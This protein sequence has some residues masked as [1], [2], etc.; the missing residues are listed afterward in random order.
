MQPREVTRATRAH[1]AVAGGSS[2]A[3]DGVH[4]VDAQCDEGKQL[5]A[6][7]ARQQWETLRT[8]ASFGVSD[9]AAVTHR[10]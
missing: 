10:D 7:A 6:L 2:G 9:T 1:D 5:A 3:M 4:L 8:E